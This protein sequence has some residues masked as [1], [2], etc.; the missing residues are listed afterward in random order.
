MRGRILCTVALL[1][2]GAGAAWG[3]GEIDGTITQQDGSGIGG[4]TIVVSETGQITLTESD[5]RF[6]ISGVPAGTY[7]V[8]F[9]LGDDAETA[10]VTVSDGEAATIDKTVDWDP[11]F[12]ETITVFSA[13]RKR[14]RIVEAPAAVT[15]IT[16][17]QIER[18]AAHGQLPKLLEHTP[19]AE[20]TQNGLYDFNFNTRGFNSSLNRRILTLI[21]GRNPSVLFL[22][23]QEHTS[24]AVP[25]DEIQS[26]ELVRGPGSALYGA[27]AFNGVVNMVTKSPRDSRGG[28]FKLTVGDLDT[29]RVDFTQSGGLGGNW[30]GRVVG[31]YLESEDYSVSRVT[32]VEY[33]G[34]DFEAVPLP[35]NTNEFF[36]GQIRADGHFD[37]G[38][39]MQIETGTAAGKTG[40]AV[41]TGIGRVQTTDFSRP[42]ARLNYSA[43][44]F[45][46]LTYHNIR[47]ADDTRSL[48]SGQPLYLDSDRTLFEF[49]ANTGF[50]GGKGRVIGGLTYSEETFDSTNPQG[51]Q[52]LVFQKVEEDFE[53][54]FGQLE[55]DFS[56]KLKG[57]FSARWDDSSLHDSQFSPRVALVW[58][59]DQRHTLRFNYG[60]AF[61]RPNYSEFFLQVQVAPPIPLRGLVLQQTGGAL[62]LEGAFCAP[63]GVNCGFDSVPLLALGNNDIEVEEVQT[64]EIGYSGIL[65]KAFLT[66]DYYNSQIENF[67][68]D[69]IG[70]INPTLGRLNAGF[71]PY[72]APSGITDPVAA[73][74]LEATLQAILTPLGLFPILS[75]SPVDETALLNAVTYTN[76]GEVDTQGLEIGLNANLTEN[77]LFNFTYNWFDFD[78]KQQLA[79]DPLFANAPENQYGLGLTY[80][81]SKYDASLKYRHV[82]G[83]DWAAGVFR[84]RI[85]SYDL[86]DFN[87][88]YHFS[89]RLEAGLNISNLLDENHYQIFGG[90]LLERRLLGHFSISW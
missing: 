66:I 90:D 83:F 46:F 60:E 10:S 81:A 82:D 35:R 57:V 26:V 64:F 13:S 61:Q 54:I 86:V 79:E 23:S 80:L 2:V 87:A 9:S 43:P 28:R 89:D 67:I 34:L 30:Y 31:G 62:D 63:F 42:Y 25:L 69:L 37:N 29:G 50:S 49:Q 73:A 53:G 51:S 19:G 32:Q 39:I 58:S 77:W 56:D 85:P 6:R 41:V 44:H 21:D 27:D 78:I 15:V 12:A 5:G 3:D 52:T 36:W 45:N 68:T 74:T 70:S 48:R 17:Q 88:T 16:E 47:D 55:Y 8:S 1:L 59:L 24:L 20:T 22:G 33:P 18:E 71:Q 7:T 72:Q 38:H 75:N 40:G 14:E 76:F 11:S 4:V 65:G 84:G